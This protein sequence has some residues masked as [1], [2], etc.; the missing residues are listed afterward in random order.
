MS[1]DK[2]ECLEPLQNLATDNKM[3]NT[4]SSL[5]VENLKL[6]ASWKEDLMR[7]VTI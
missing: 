4:T 7:M 1:L 2:I 5:R 3:T 6:C